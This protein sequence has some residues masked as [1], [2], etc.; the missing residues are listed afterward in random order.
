MAILLKDIWPVEN[1][2]DLKVHFARYNNHIE[3]LDDW[4][5]DR[6]QWY[7]WQEYRPK[8]NEFSRPFIFSL[9]RF[10]RES[11][12]WLFGG[13][14][15]VLADQGHRYEVQLTDLGENFIGRLKI[16]RAYR[17]RARRVNFENHY[18]EMEVLEI[19]REPYS[20]RAFP[21]YE[22]IDLPLNELATLIENERPDWKS[23]LENVKG[24][25]LIT[26]TRTGKRYVGKA[27]GDQGIWSRWREYVRTGHGWNKELRELVGDRLEYARK[28]FK[29]TLLEYRPAPT[30]D[31]TIDDRESYWKEV[32]L[33]R[34]R[35]GLNQN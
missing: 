35:Y 16:H 31:E 34:G 22:Y 23:A 27:S 15:R 13:V 6:A 7:N 18:N 1:V 28:Y 33:T 21:G 2:Y 17:S 10:Y 26:D 8:R 3:P 9:M 20:G 32:L 29:F 12:V 19:L 11:D 5:E 25:Y 30:P 24:V 14:F 4:L